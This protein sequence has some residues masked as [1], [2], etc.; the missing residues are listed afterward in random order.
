ME[1]LTIPSVGASFKKWGCYTPILP[2][3]LAHSPNFQKKL[4]FKLIFSKEWRQ[5]LIGLGVNPW[6][7]TSGRPPAASRRLASLNFVLFS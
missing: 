5:S 2:K 3:A 7:A 1:H 6:L 4:I